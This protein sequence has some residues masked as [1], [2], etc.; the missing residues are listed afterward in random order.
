MTLC[1]SP[2]R[3]PRWLQP[4]WSR[5]HDWRYGKIDPNRPPGERGEQAA[6]RLLRFH[7]LTIVGQ[8]VADRFGEIDLI[9]L[10]RRHR[11]VI[12]V[13]VKTLVTR[14]PG[15]PADRVDDAKQTQITRAALRFLRR[16]RLLNAR[17]RFDVVAVWWPDSSTPLP[18]RIEHYP[19]AFEAS[20][21]DGFYS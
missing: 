17:V 14:K 9:A 18:E 3:W 10:D 2:H 6:A 5:W 7:G 12:F 19:A 13:E 8:Q 4:W 16:Q 1:P 21:V 11:L 20:G 15:H